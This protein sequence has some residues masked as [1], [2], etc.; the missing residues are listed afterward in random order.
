MNGSSRSAM[1]I[2]NAIV[3]GK[4]VVP[5][6]SKTSFQILALEAKKQ[7]FELVN[8]EVAEARER[9][10]ALLENPAHIESVL[11]QGAEK[12]RDY[13]SPFLR[14]L[15]KAVGIYSFTV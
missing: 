13:A 6:F 10:N 11:R 8:N 5:Y 1:L 2:W 15:R 12:A 7:L 4:L 3:Q 9:Y 14:E